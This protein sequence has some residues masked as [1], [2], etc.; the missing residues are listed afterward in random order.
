MLNHIWKFLKFIERWEYFDASSFWGVTVGGYFLVQSIVFGVAPRAT[1][2]DQTCQPQSVT[3]T[4]VLYTR[5]IP[6]S[7]RF[8]TYQ[9]CKIICQK[10]STVLSAMKN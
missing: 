3:V 5:Q 1:G 7:A 10:H 8:K 9:K 4:N 6:F 2:F